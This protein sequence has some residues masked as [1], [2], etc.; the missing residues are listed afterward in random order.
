MFS[1]ANDQL[2]QK[3]RALFKISEATTDFSRSLSASEVLF[4]ESIQVCVSEGWFDYA[5]YL[6]A[7]RYFDHRR[8]LRAALATQASIRGSKENINC[9]NDLLAYAQSQYIDSRGWC[10]RQARIERSLPDDE[11][12]ATA[13]QLIYALGQK[14]GQLPE[15]IRVEIDGVLCDRHRRRIL[16]GRNSEAGPLLNQST[17]QHA[18][19]GLAMSGGGIRSASFSIG[20]LQ[21]M[22]AK[23][24][25]P[26]F[27]YIS[28]VSGGGYAASWFLAWAYRHK[29]GMD[30]VAKELASRRGS[31]CG[32]LWWVRR[33][34][35]YLAPRFSLSS[36]GD[37]IALVAAY[38]FNWIPI[39]TLMCLAL[40]S[41]LLVPRVLAEMIKVL[42]ESTD[43]YKVIALCITAGA[44]TLLIGA[45]RTLTMYLRAPAKPSRYPDGL[46]P[47][48][49]FVFALLALILSLTIPAVP[50]ALKVGAFQEAWISVFPRPPGGFTAMLIVWS[51]AYFFGILIAYLLGRTCSVRLIDF[52]LLKIWSRARPIRNPSIIIPVHPWQFML[53]AAL[54][55]IV[56]S[57]LS[58]ALVPFASSGGGERY[59][60]AVGPLVIV[61]VVAASELCNAFLSHSRMREI[62]RAWMSQVA[63][64]MLAGSAIWFGVSALSLLSDDLI[65]LVAAAGPVPQSIL[66]ASIA[67]L[68]TFFI[69]RKLF[70]LAGSV[71]ALTFLVLFSGIGISKLVSIWLKW[72]NTSL[73]WLAAGLFLSTLVLGSI[74]NVNRFSMHALYREG[75]VR[76][77]LGASR[78]GFRNPNI[79]APADAG[80]DERQQFNTR[81]P[82]PITSIDD[83]DN[84]ALCWL[85][86]RKN[87][88]LPMF[89]L[90]AAVNGLNPGD[91]DGRVPRQWPYT[92]S[93]VHCGS[94]ASG[95]GYSR[96]E[97]VFS[98][99]NTKSI[100]LGT[101]MAVSGAA[102]SPTS[103]HGTNPIKAFVLGL[104]NARLGLWIG[105]P[106]KPETVKQES[107]KLTGLTII[108]EAMALRWRFGNWLHLSD[109]GHF[110]NLGVYELLRRGCSRIVVVDGSCDPEEQMSDL[111]NAIRRAR[112]DLGIIVR[113]STA[114]DFALDSFAPN[115]NLGSFE[116]GQVGSSAASVNGQA[117]SSI[118]GCGIE[119][120]FSDSPPEIGSSIVTSAGY[121]DSN[122][123]RPES[124]E[125]SKESLETQADTERAWQW[126]TVDYGEGLPLGR[127][128]YIKPS[129][130]GLTKLPIEVHQ[131]AKLGKGFPHETTVDQFFTEAQ[132][133]AYRSLGQASGE[134]ALNVALKVG[135]SQGQSGADSGLTE[136]MRRRALQ[137]VR[138]G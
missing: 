132:L 31:E 99:G 85:R 2:L 93:P 126:F 33:H 92:F 16:L 100:T 135:R 11:I 108:S 12:Q 67:L 136:R 113:H 134:D 127:M 29:D 53:G 125:F 137:K 66:A 45:V 129:L 68:L 112:I 104:L 9:L 42:T 76:T 80:D 23:G 106:Q 115:Q 17:H 87:R 118:A 34:S 57:S 78:L 110:E 44:L 32:P 60:A 98:S 14:M 19:I 36:A 43:S 7:A 15:E 8:A 4:L 117:G 88:A 82:D 48:A 90:N 107:P 119:Q 89:L 77:F 69:A 116:R 138:A 86:T 123:R 39:F 13:D 54:G 121:R 128:L 109:G 61:Q 65:A 55:I 3:L 28:S 102:V 41:V 47:L 74:I 120:V 6:I 5:R 81:T 91:V 83:D 24:L 58:D 46:P 103:G 26:G 73:F 70:L 56:G 49:I 97:L 64:W 27:H 37:L 130:E 133:E 111:A 22:A 50:S 114:L 105:N 30:G 96:T 71:L 10:G 1:I 51:C 122:V 63:A 124:N 72:S 79:V 25:L 21:A 131:Y 84:P 59:V 101:A 20:V 40:A 18:L 75:L 95:I 62:D 35:S 94:P 52:M 38:L